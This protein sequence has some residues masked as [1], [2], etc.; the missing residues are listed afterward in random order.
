MRGLLG[1][2]EGG[3]SR[4]GCSGHVP[5]KAN[6]RG[7]ATVVSCESVTPQGC[8]RDLHQPL[9]RQAGVATRL[10]VKP[11]CGDSVLRPSWKLC[12]PSRAALEVPIIQKETRSSLETGGPGFF[13]SPPGTLTGLFHGTRQRRGSPSPSLCVQ[14]GLSPRYRLHMY[15][16]QS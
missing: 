5:R 14:P 15:N 7:A 4:S 11:K 3:R 6:D 16:F 10:A 8:S 2:T 12:N 9:C 1:F 13:L